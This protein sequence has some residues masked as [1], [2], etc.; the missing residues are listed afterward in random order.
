M[1]ELSSKVDFNIVRYAN[2]WE[3]ADVLLAALHVPPGKRILCIASAGDNALSLLTTY[4]QQVIA[5]DISLPQLYL[6]QLKQAAFKEL[7]HDELL[8]FLGI[9]TSSSKTTLYNRLRQHL[10]NAAATYWDERQNIIEAGLIHCGKFERYFATFRKYLL[11]LV[12]SRKEIDQLLAPKSEQAQAIFYKR[13]WNSLRWRMLMALFFSKYVMGKYGR[14]PQFLKHVNLSVP[15]YIRS[16]AEAQLSSTAC[17][18]NYLLHMIFTGSFGNELPHYLRREN[19]EIIHANID[20]LQ[21]IHADADTLVHQ[22]P[23]DAYYF[24]N[25]FEY[26]S[27]DV[28]NQLVTEWQ[29]YIPV[30]A[31]LAYWNLMA[32]RSFSQSAPDHYIYDENSE[33]YARNDKG[34]FYSSFLHEYKK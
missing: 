11:P 29:S 3:D 34:F 13:K 32:P 20:K 8:S 22:Q 23:F 30:G 27:A 6:A 7:T 19:Y 18:H 5:A 25:I 33:L 16:K 15:D 17:Q 14:D 9:I 31:S 21:F 2:C 1:T 12:H 4:P 24:S 26:L 28:F 10:P